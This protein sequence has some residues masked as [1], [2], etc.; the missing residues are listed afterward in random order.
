M[1]SS[2]SFLSPSFIFF[3]VVLVISN[4]LSVYLYNRYYVKPKANKN[5][6]DAVKRAEEEQRARNEEERKQEEERKKQ[7]EEQ[8]KKEE[9]EQKR[10]IED[11]SMSGDD[12]LSW[13]D[14]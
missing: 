2:S 5:I 13:L 6:K 12:S 7:E 4:I 11:N 9:P 14:V 1:E 8:K 10:G 3:L